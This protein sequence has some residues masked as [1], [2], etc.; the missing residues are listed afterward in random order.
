MLRVATLG[1]LMLACACHRKDDADTSTDT[2]GAASG[3]ASGS[4]MLAANGAGVVREL[5]GTVTVEGKPLAVGDRV[6]AGDVVTTGDGS[7]VMIELLHNGAKWELGPNRAVRVADSIVW[8]MTAAE[9]ST[10]IAVRDMAQPNVPPATAPTAP[11]AP[12]A[13]TPKGA[14]AVLMV[15]RGALMA[16]LDAKSTSVHLLVQVDATGKPK[17]DA[18]SASAAE[19][20][21][22]VATVAKLTFPHEQAGVGITL[23][24]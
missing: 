4:A 1:I 9:A 20:T 11:T 10:G 15:H 21:C 23:Q 6:A 18:P 14:A 8:K 24:K 19:R 5:S 7:R 13:T 22:L 16:C 12:V 17:L 2:S 3:S